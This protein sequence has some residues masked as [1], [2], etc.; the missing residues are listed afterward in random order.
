[1][2]TSETRAA[3]ATASTISEPV[4]GVIGGVVAGA[5]YLVAQISLTAATRA[6]GAA[7]PLQRIA[8]ILMGPDAAPPPSEFNFTVFGMA[9]IIH[10][11]LAMAFG[12][13]VS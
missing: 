5:A 6:G 1:M 2:Q 11:A 7:E 8:A 12:R 9:L 3:A 10:F 4:A 13:L